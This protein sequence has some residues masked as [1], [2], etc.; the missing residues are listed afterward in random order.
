MT[1]SQ[2]LFIVV[3]NIIV[4][5]ANLVVPRCVG[6]FASWVAPAPPPSSATGSPPPAYVGGGRASN[7]QSRRAPSSR[8]NLA[9]IRDD[10]GNDDAD[11]GRRG[12]GGA[13]VDVDDDRSSTAGG[14]RI[15][16]IIQNIG[17][18]NKDEIDEIVKLCI[19]VFFNDGGAWDHDDDEVVIGTNG[20]V[21]NGRGRSRRAAMTPWKAMQL[22]YLRKFQT[23]DI[24]AR[25]AFRR[26]QL[27]DLIIARRVHPVVYG[28]G[29]TVMNGN[30]GDVIDDVRRIYNVDTTKA[31]PNV[32]YR[33]GEI[34]GY[35]EVSEKNF[36]LGDNY[37]N[38]NNN[39]RRRRK[40][41][42]KS[43][44][45]YL[46]NLSVVEG[47][48]KSG[49]GSRLLDACVQAV[50]DWDGNYTEIVLQVEEDNPIAIQFYKR[51]GWEFVFADPTCR[52][53]DTS[54]IFLRETRITKYAMVKRL[55]NDF[56]NRVQNERESDIVGSQF[57]QRLRSSF[58]VQ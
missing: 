52:R 28:G 47:A 3:T 17:R 25:N 15:P 4:I 27:V 32:T 34:I 22:A 40:D 24:L 6:T 35:C 7:P 13:N 53:Y 30:G 45:P 14:G 5:R 44:R 49:I 48:R 57:R 33:T 10:D 43:T 37:V 51:R 1:A 39:G 18:G 42:D 29:T 56:G 38:D 16:F 8:I 50:R 46:S 58:F 55:D 2:L 23:G 11:G 19:D 41:A 54:G 9:N 12:G 26:D 21:G 36:G 20:I 31:S